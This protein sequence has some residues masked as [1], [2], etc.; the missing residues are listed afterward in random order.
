MAKKATTKAEAPAQNSASVFP[1]DTEKSTGFVEEG[2]DLLP[3]E[4]PPGFDPFTDA[5]PV[6]SSDRQFN[7]FFKFQQPGD[8][9]TGR[10]LGVIQPEGFDDPIAIFEDWPQKGY[11]NVSAINMSHSISAHFGDLNPDDVSQ[12]V[13]RITFHQEKEAKKGTYKDLRIVRAIV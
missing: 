7:E 3:G 5:E 12:Y 11:R 8:Q 13:Y 2:S 4:R 10:F 6:D 9:Y 1:E